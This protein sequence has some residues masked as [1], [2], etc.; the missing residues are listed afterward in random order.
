MSKEQE[1]A[2]ASIYSSQLEFAMEQE[3]DIRDI[4]AE[5]AAAI[6]DSGLKDGI[7]TVFVPGATGA[8]TCL[9]YEP[10]VIADFQAAVERIAPRD[11]HYQHNINLSDGNGHGHVRAGLLGPS[12]S[13]PFAGGEPLLGVWQQVVLV[14]FDNRSRSRRVV[15]QAVGA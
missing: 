6:K 4:T 8:V 14:N 13:V 9:E 2:P 1:T 5:F 11:M 7:A 10:G 3:L 15:I 12:L